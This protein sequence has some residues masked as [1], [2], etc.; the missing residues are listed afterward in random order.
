MVRAYLA[1]VALVAVQR[2]FELYLSRRHA[3]F[4][5]A[6]GGIEVGRSHYFWIRL[7]HTAF[8]ASAPLEVVLLRRSF[9]P[10]L[11]I[12]MFS[13]FLLTQALRYWAIVSL[14]PYW[15]VRVIVVPGTKLVER[16]PY[17]Y[18]RHP[19]YL[20]IVVEFIALPLVHTAWLTATAFSVLNAW[21]LTV[22]IRCENQALARYCLS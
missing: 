12:P 5:L 19:N 11:G 10:E 7:L 13:V 16:G 2:L 6:Q 9:I 1:L 22:R 17:R 18:L 15:N 8:L 20:A 21:M 3:S 14:G 4:T